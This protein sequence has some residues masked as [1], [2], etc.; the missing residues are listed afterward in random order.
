MDKMRKLNPV[1]CRIEKG[2]GKEVHLTFVLSL[3][4]F[5]S[6]SLSLSFSLPLSLFLSPSLP[7]LSLSL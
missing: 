2:K 5:L 7:F 4:L 1:T 3:S 6:F